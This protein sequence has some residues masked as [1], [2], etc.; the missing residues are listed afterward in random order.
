MT[1]IASHRIASH[2]TRRHTRTE[3]LK[4]EGGEAPLSLSLLSMNPPTA[5]RPLLDA[6]SP[7]LGKERYI[8]TCTS[9]SMS[10]YESRS[11]TATLTL[12]SELKRWSCFY[13]VLGFS[14]V[15]FLAWYLAMSCFRNVLSTLDEKV[16]LAAKTAS[17]TLVVVVALMC[18]MICSL[19]FCNTM[20]ALLGLFGLECPFSKGNQEKE[21][22]LEPGDLASPYMKYL[23]RAE[24]EAIAQSSLYCRLDK[25]ARAALGVGGGDALKV[26]IDK[27][28]ESVLADDRLNP[29]FRNPVVSIQWLKHHQYQFLSRLFQEGNN[30]T[31]YTG[32]SIQAAHSR[33]AFEKGLKPWHLDCLFEDLDEVMTGLSIPEDIKKDA[34]SLL[35]MFR[36]TFETLADLAEAVT[37]DRRKK[38][39]SRSI[40]HLSQEYPMVTVL[41]AD[42]VRFMDLCKN[43][44]PR[45]IMY[46]LNDLF[47]SYDS[48]LDLY[49]VEKIETVGDCYVLVGGMSMSE[50]ELQ[51]ELEGLE[52]H[53]QKTQLRTMALEDRRKGALN[54][55]NM[56]KAMIKASECISRIDKPGEKIKIRIGMHSGPCVSGVV[57]TEKP[58]LC[59]FGDTINVASRMETSGRRPTPT[60][61]PSSLL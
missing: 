39:T 50:K 6:L 36:P 33:L 10:M 18:G 29:M 20:R 43:Q 31:F 17:P 32:R 3:R 25:W 52:G 61:L 51:E 34:M 27:L 15:V 12:A 44:E 16:L 7:K 40:N 8:S 11:P 19:F 54:T 28:Y 24:S 42:V 30:E 2:R 58:R 53:A 14:Y 49:D 60:P 59:L 56:A 4:G 23:M 47:E 35:E 13:A 46:L 21:K 57:G 22:G 37:T 45:T 5:L 48:I 1:G 41:F 38:L 9:M 55:F 26:L